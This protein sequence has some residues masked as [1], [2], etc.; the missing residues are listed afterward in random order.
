VEVVVLIGVVQ[1]HTDMLRADQI[2][3]VHRMAGE[4]VHIGLARRH[5]SR[6]RAQADHS[7]GRGDRADEVVGEV[8]RRVAH[9][10]RVAVA[11]DHRLPGQLDDL[12]AG[13]C[14]GV[15]DVGNDAKGVEPADRRP[16]RLAESAIGRFQAAI[17]QLVPVVV[18]QLGYSQAQRGVAFEQGERCQP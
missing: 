12:Q 4:I 1:A 15:R 17:G 6:E 2:R 8:A 13:S 10:P 5:E 16:A 7:A 11:G 18:S 14:P 9:R 3:D